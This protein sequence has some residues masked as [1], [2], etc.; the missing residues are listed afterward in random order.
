MRIIQSDWSIEDCRSLRDTGSHQYRTAVR[1]LQIS[2]GIA[3]EIPDVISAYKSVYIQE[4][5]A[6][7][8][9]YALTQRQREAEQAAAALAALGAG[10]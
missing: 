7:E 3:R 8:E 4:I 6:R 2:D 1:R 9:A 5:D 10:S